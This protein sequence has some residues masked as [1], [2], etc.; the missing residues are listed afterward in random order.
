MQ[1]FDL[2]SDFHNEMARCSSPLGSP[3]AKS[4]HNQVVTDNI[5]MKSL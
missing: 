5:D 1:D 2:Q 3:T 4:I